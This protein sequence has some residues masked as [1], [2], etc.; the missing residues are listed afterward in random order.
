MNPE[1]LRIVSLVLAVPLGL[2]GLAGVVTGLFYVVADLSDP[3]N[4]WYGLGIALGLVLA[5][6]CLVV[7]SL[8]VAG[9]MA[10]RGPGRAGHGMLLAASAVAVLAL[11]AFGLLTTPAFWVAAVPT[12]ALAVLSLIGLTRPD[13]PRRSANLAL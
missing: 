1:R 4:D 5:V 7:L 11:G 12:T 10:L 3:G 6:P 9:L 13:A 2:L 8:L